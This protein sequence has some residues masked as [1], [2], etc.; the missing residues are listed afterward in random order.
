[1]TAFLETLQMCAKAALVCVVPV[2]ALGAGETAQFIAAGFG[3][4]SYLMSKDQ[5]P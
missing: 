3:A 1:M 5:T 4:L 2:G